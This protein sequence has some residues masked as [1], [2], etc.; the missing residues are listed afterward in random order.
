MTESERIRSDIPLD[1]APAAVR[2]TAREIDDP[3]L[4]AHQCYGCGVWIYTVREESVSGPIH[5]EIDEDG[6]PAGPG[7]LIVVYDQYS[8]PWLPDAD[9]DEYFCP[10]CYDELRGNGGL[11]RIRSPQGRRM[12]FRSL[13]GVLTHADYHVHDDGGRPRDHVAI[14]AAEALVTRGGVL[15]WEAGW[16]ATTAGDREITGDKMVKALEGWRF[17]HNVPS[18]YD[19]REAF[20]NAIFDEEVDIPTAVVA[21][22]SY[23][24]VPE[25]DVEMVRETYKEYARERARS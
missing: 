19:V 17:P 2:E 6:Y 7:D 24:W 13:H 5:A 10:P 14:D 16:Y 21:A 1:D 15:P 23:L 25:D 18:T 9:G 3:Y 4:E 22:S 20:I 11:L 12:A 8:D